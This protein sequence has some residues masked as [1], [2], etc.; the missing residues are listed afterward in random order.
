[1]RRWT[2]RTILTASGTL[3]AGCSSPNPD[4]NAPTQG[5]TQPTQEWRTVGYD[6][7]HTGYLPAANLVQNG[8]E[9]WRAKLDSRGDIV[10]SPVIVDGVV[11]AGSGRTVYS[12]SL[13]DGS[14]RWATETAFDTGLHS[15]TVVDGTLLLS[16]I[17]AEGGALLA[18]D[19]DTGAIEWRHSA[20]VATATT[21]H[22]GSAYIGTENPERALIAVDESTGEEA[23]SVA[24]SGKPT[25]YAFRTAPA[26]HGDTVYIATTGTGTNSRSSSVLHAVSIDGTTRWSTSLAGRTDIVPAVDTDTVYVG[27]SAG[28][29]YAVSVKTGAVQWS[30]A[31]T[32]SVTT[33][34]A[35]DADHAYLG[36]SDGSF[37][38]IDKNR[39]TE[40]WSARATVLYTDPVVT[41]GTVYVGGETV[42][43]R[44]KGDGAVRW[45]YDMSFEGHTSFTSPVVVD[46]AMLIGA[47]TKPKRHQVSYE[48]YVVALGA[49]AETYRS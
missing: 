43:A 42:Q 21:V 17:A 20:A 19:T 48:N 15:G 35:I 23:W 24:F 28:T 36:T 3:M 44:D 14:E 41:E 33:S 4:P 37:Y 29:V 1:M 12:I 13:E 10:G 49:A 9:T 45:V 6:S 7:A 46:G 38:A 26:V 16:G 30:T 47:C 18:F 27:T 2:R 22:E 8:A 5:R 39:G 31:V 34:P 11:Y 25:V 40:S 32:G